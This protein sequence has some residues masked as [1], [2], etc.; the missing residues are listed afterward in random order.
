MQHSSSVP[1]LDRRMFTCVAT[2]KKG[3]LGWKLRTCTC[4][5]TQGPKKREARGQMKATL[6]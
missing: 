2:K 5:R 3:L 1:H 6:T 4:I